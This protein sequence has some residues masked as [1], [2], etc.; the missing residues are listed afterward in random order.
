MTSVSVIIPTWNRAELV[1][2][3]VHSAQKQTFSPAEILVC[4]DGS[5]DNTMEIV[6][7]IARIDARVKWI[8]GER[9]GRPAIPRN[10]GI[11]ASRGEWLA[12]L[13][14]DDEWRNDKLERQLDLVRRAR[15]LAACSNAAR[16]IP[17]KGVDGNII[18]WRKERLALTDLLELN[19]VVCSSSVIH[20]SLFSEVIGFPEN[21]HLKA[22]EDYALWLRVAT[23]T[24]FAYCG[25]P[26]VLYR[27]EPT[28]SVRR[29]SSSP[30]QQKGRV[31]TNFMAWAVSH[32]SLYESANC[33]GQVMKKFVKELWITSRCKLSAMVRSF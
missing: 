32:N 1:A 18:D 6:R 31:F 20:R 28:A 16:L 21:K 12:F 4:D 8:G 22:L 10:R 33:A 19:R 17:D 29:E 27:D 14:S 9:G 7:E 23:R 30:L 24:D 15:C 26:L 11:R 25:E 3:A 5:S 13:D 2:A